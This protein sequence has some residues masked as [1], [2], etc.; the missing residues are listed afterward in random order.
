MSEKVSCLLDT[1]VV[2]ELVRRPNGEVARRV[3]L[4]DPRSFAIS[5]IVAAELRYGAARRGSARLSS[6]VEAVLSAIAVLPLEEP[7][8][9]HY[10][11]IRSE[12]ERIGQPIGHND[13][14]IAAH[15]RALGATLVTRN[16][17]EFHRVSGLSVESWTQETSGDPSPGHSMR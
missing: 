2:S 6:Q 5:V 11:V 7:V 9:R 8:D 14:L 12:L 4:L 17:R 13:L 1:N 3:V 16:L 15:A 10:A